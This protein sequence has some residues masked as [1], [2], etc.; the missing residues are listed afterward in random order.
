M[1]NVQVSNWRLAPKVEEQPT[2]RMLHWR[3][4]EV[5]GDLRVLGWIKEGP[6]TRMTSP[7]R[8]LLPTTRQVITHSGR[9]YEM[10]QP[11]TEDTE[12][13]VIILAR[14]AAERILVTNDRSYEVWSAMVQAGH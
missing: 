11:P 8:A 6:T 10:D 7:L 2:V 4:F 12:R 9:I 13:L 3:I 1:I 5:D 14:L